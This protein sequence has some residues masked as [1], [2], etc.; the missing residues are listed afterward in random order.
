VNLHSSD[1]SPNQEFST[2][3]REE[4]LYN[5]EKLLANGD[6]AE[7]EIAAKLHCKLSFYLGAMYLGIDHIHSR[8][9]LPVT[10]LQAIAFIFD[11]WNW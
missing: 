9:R 3:T 8:L 11:K 6:W 7:A 10:R 4:L 2:E 5:K 1:S